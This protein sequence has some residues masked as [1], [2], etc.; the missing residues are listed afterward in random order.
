M[1]G[2]LLTRTPRYH[3]LDEAPIVW[4]ICVVKDSLVKIV[5][6]TIEQY[7][8]LLEGDK[9][10]VALS[11]GP[12]S[13]CL[14]N[15]LEELRPRYSLSLCIAHFNHKLRG[16]A[17]DRDADFCE[18][19]ARRRGIPFVTD[20]A[21]VMAFANERKWSMEE[22]ARALRYEFLLRSSLSL[23]A[24]KVA[25]G[26]TADDQAETILMRLI[27]GAG[28][29]G[30][31]G[32]PPIRP[33]RTPNGPILI[34]PLIHVWRT[35]IVRYARARS[36]AYR[37]DASNE[38]PQYLR[39]RVRLEL[40]PHLTKYNPKIKQR[41]TGAASALAVE[42]DFIAGEASRLAEEIA[43]AKR[44]GE[45]IFDAARLA[46]LHPALRT[47]ILSALV[48]SVRP[49][50]PMLEAVHYDEVD[51]LLCAVKGR[52]DLPGKLRLELSEGVGL[53]CDGARS[54]KIPKGSFGV[55]MGGKT[56]IP[57]LNLAV[58]TR[59][60]ENISSP[61]R[62]IRLCN[63]NRQY[64]ALDAVRSPLEIRLRRPG[65][66]LRP[67]GGRGTKKVQDFFVDRKVPRF[68]RDRVP[69]LLSD[70]RIMWVMGYAI[71]KKYMLTPGSRAALR[72]DYERRS[73]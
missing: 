67:L 65:D 66:S 5:K 58:T 11:G 57:E 17:S 50:T 40:I 52:I 18:R 30:L 8:M 19:T 27:R 55:A 28:P 48:T 41:L 32:M 51:A 71:D 61:S 70:G 62:L 35:D 36:L 63:P 1:R 10:L 34:R 4:Y 42:N 56:I 2:Q 9:V 16:K 33:L 44:P 13:V 23:G 72:V 49:S 47:R 53:I 12:D 25:M 20:A 64:F 31:E 69:L 60:L 15:V 45:V 26:H 38:S 22:A 14:L 6:R 29:H 46:S 43:M 3:S 68:L 39:N 73:S 24:T 37:K 54:P 59:V 21:D 7:H